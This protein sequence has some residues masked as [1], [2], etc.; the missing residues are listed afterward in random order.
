[1]G[2]RKQFLMHG[3]FT[4]VSHFILMIVTIPLLLPHGADTDIVLHLKDT[5]LQKMATQDVKIRW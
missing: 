4:I 1:M 3:M 2:K 5:L